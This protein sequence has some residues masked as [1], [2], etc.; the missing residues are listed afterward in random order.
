MS[1]RDRLDPEVAAFIGASAAG[2]AR[3]PP[4]K[5]G[6]SYE[7]S[8]QIIDEMGVQAAA[9]GPVM[10]ETT[11]RCWPPEVAAFCAVCISHAQTQ[12]CL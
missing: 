8:R 12:L 11:D 4:I 2:A 5:M 3:F 1:D 10:A 6:I 9:G 7:P